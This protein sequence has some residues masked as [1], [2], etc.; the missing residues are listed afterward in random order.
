MVFDNRT[1]SAVRARVSIKRMTLKPVDWCEILKDCEE[2]VRGTRIIG[3]EQGMNATA[4]CVLYSVCK[5]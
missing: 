3:V 2:S 4:N 1:L 5:S